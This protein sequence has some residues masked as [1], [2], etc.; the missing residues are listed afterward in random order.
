MKKIGFV[1]RKFKDKLFQQ[2]HGEE[3]N[4][5]GAHLGFGECFVY[6]LN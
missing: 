1:A 3:K 2:N 5:F 6:E 4:R